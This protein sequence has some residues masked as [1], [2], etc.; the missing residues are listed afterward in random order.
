MQNRK[1]KKILAGMLAMTMI[2]GSTLTAFAAETSGSSTGTG[3]FEGHVDQNVVLV[4]LPTQTTDLYN[5]TID[6]EGLIAK[7]GAS[8]YGEEVTFEEGKSVYFQSEANKYTGKSAAAK[9][10]N[11]GTVDIDLTVTAKTA[12]N[13]KVTMVDAVSEF[14]ESTDALLFLELDVSGQK[15][16]VKT[17]DTGKVEVG[18]CGNPANYEVQYDTESGKYVF[19]TKA[20]TPATAWNYCEVTLSG[21]CN[22]AGDWS[23]EALAASDVT[24]TWSYAAQDGTDDFTDLA[25]NATTE[26]AP[27]FTAGETAGTINYTAGSGN[28]ALKSI[29]SIKGTKNG[30]AYD[31]F[32]AY[33]GLWDAATMA[34]GVITFDNDFLSRFTTDTIEL[35]ITAV[36]EDG[37]EIT[38]TVIVTKPTE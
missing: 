31:G 7:T 1:F 14:A 17:D 5:Y 4:Q 21:A 23:A 12:E 6:P 33:S 32:N 37:S 29:T 22:T 20:N 30:T 15:A 2:F 3:T 11:M 19:G 16:A 18:L 34:D 35:T 10:V 25:E 24:V 38:E 9:V 8:K 36:A 27:T 26:S 13:T 28:K